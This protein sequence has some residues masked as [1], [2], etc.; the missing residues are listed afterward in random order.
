V[1]QISV[2]GALG[3]A[4]IDPEDKSPG[5]YDGPYKRF[6]EPD[7]PIFFAGDHL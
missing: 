6:I 7:G 2:G 3:S 5:Y 1:A 4:I